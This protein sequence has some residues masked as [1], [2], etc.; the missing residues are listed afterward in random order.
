MCV[1]VRSSRY[2]SICDI[3]CYFVHNQRSFK[4]YLSYANKHPDDFYI[5]FHAR[6]STNWKTPSLSISYTHL[7]IWFFA[8][9]NDHLLITHVVMFCI[10]PLNVQK[11][12]DLVHVLKLF[13]HTFDLSSI[14]IFMKNI[15][16]ILQTI[17]EP[18]IFVWIYFLWCY[19]KTI[20][21]TVYFH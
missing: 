5:F 4:M 16:V 15:V 13:R 20:F 14:C 6:S 3:I 8:I 9:E 17:C 11:C 2:L 7:F 21:V 1:S 18:F 19:Y 10:N 12:H